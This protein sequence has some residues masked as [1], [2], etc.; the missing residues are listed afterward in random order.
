MDD[1]LSVGSI[2]PD[3][4]ILQRPDAIGGARQRYIAPNFSEKQLYLSGYGRHWGEKITYSVGL[5]YGSGMLLGGSFGFMKGVSKGGATRKLV[6]NSI[7]NTCGTYGPKL[8]NGAACI[9]LLYCVMNSSTKFALGDKIDDRLI[10][11][12]VGANAGALYKCKG[13]WRALAKCSIGSA[14]AF[15]AIDY[16]LRYSLL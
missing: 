5:A 2:K 7:L 16:A 15:T 1:Y 3:L 12:I 10:A 14:V 9:T 8:G 11:P 6:I 13:T 4:D